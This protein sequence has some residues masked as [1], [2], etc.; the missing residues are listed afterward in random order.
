MLYDRGVFDV[1]R[2]RSPRLVAWSSWL[3]PQVPEHEP[4]P[5]R[6]VWLVATYTVRRWLFVDRSTGLAAT[7]SM[8][9]LLSI[10][11]IAAVLMVFVRLVDPKFGREFV[12]QVAETLIPEGANPDAIAGQVIELGENASVAK[13]GVWSFLGVVVLAYWLYSTLENTCNE[14]WRVKRRRPLVSKFTMFYTLASLAP[15]LVLYSLAQPTLSRVTNTFLVTPFLTTSVGLILVNRF[16]PNT[17]VKWWAAASGGLLSA[18]LFELGKWGFGLYVSRVSMSTYENVYGSAALLPVFVIWSSL[19]WMIV[20]LGIELSY[21]LHHLP[22]VH[23]QGYVP[24][25]HRAERLPPS[26]PGRTA[27]RLMLAIA[28]NYARR[29]RGIS[30]EKL[31][32]RFDLGLGRV[33]DLVDRME[34]AGLLVHTSDELEP[35]Y[36]PG[37]PLEQIEVL[38]VLALFARDVDRSRADV[39]GDLFHQ[40]DRHRDRKLAGL[41]FHDLV[42]EERPHEDSAH[43]GTSVGLPTVR[44]S[45]SASGLGRP[46]LAQDGREPSPRDAT[47]GRDP[48]APNASATHDGGNLESTEMTASSITSLGSDPPKSA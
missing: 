48:Q 14:I 42:T 23:R 16:M 21:V 37:R 45:A 31:D 1:L 30:P 4:S 28:D 18:L 15:V 39:L 29:E 35:G 3:W 44:A 41:S 27:A 10:V 19:S 25:G 40:L 6:R 43:P 26:A 47:P 33:M 38:E 46:D 32:E 36:V 8:Q 9:T 20:L 17:Q 11:P 24:P 34:E 22:T 2:G 12:V 7:L 13:L 5:A